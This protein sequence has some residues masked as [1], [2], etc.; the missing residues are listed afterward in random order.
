MICEVGKSYTDRK[1]RMWLVVG[2][3]GSR[4]Y[5]VTAERW[6]GKDY[7][8]RCFQRDG[9]FFVGRDDPMDLVKE[10]MA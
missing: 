6:E 3:N 5:P 8:V 7:R 4:L 2:V 10:M 9:R 1:G